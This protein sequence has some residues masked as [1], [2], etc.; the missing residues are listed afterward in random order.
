MQKDH[1]TQ[2]KQGLIGSGWVLQGTHRPELAARRPGGLRFLSVDKSFSKF[3]EPVGSFGEK[4]VVRV[5]IVI[6]ARA[7][8]SVSGEGSHFKLAPR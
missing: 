6:G 1:G 4:D 8:V 2:C 7:T 3:V 5:D